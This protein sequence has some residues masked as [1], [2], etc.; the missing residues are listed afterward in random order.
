MTS[1]R[2]GDETGDV[3]LIGKKKKNTMPGHRLVVELVKTLRLLSIPSEAPPAP[4]WIAFS[5]LWIAFPLL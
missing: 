3:S 1:H 4:F 2:D 5:L